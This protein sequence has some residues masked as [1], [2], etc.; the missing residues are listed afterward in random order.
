[1]DKKDLIK[2]LLYQLILIIPIK[3][4]ATNSLFFQN[5]N[6]IGSILLYF[7]IS[8]FL[9][10]IVATAFEQVYPLKIDTLF[11]YKHEISNFISELRH[12]EKLEKYKNL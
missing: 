2:I 12:K 8:F 9:F 4:L 1:M 3:C 10:C 7:V 6:I 5:T 11:K